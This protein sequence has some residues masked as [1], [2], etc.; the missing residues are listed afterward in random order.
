MSVRDGVQKRRYSL[1]THVSDRYQRPLGNNHVCPLR[2]KNKAGQCGE[3]ARAEDSESFQSAIRKF[4]PPVGR[5]W[6]SHPKQADLPRRCR[7][8][9]PL[10][11]RRQGI[12]SKIGYRLLSILPPFRKDP[13]A[14]P[15]VLVPRLIIP[16]H[17]SPD[18][19]RAKYCQR[20]QPQFAPPLHGTD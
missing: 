15:F 12:R 9:Y 20:D 14:Q 18:E 10:Y 3:G 8:P 5:K 2:E 13:L 16:R 7:I 4:T 17:Q 1:N 19:S 11:Q 6:S